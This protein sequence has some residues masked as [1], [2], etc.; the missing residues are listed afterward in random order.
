MLSSNSSP[1]SFLYRKLPTRLTIY[2][3]LFILSV[4]LSLLG[5]GALVYKLEASNLNLD[6]T[7]GIEIFNVHISYSFVLILFSAF[8][9]LS[10][11]LN[12]FKI[13]LYLA[14]LVTF[15]LYLFPE[16]P[17]HRYLILFT[18]PL[19]ISTLFKNRSINNVKQSYIILSIVYFYAF[20]A[21]LNYSYINSDISCAAIFLKNILSLN[22]FT[23]NNSLINIKWLNYLSIYSSIIL[24]FLFCFFILLKRTRKAVII[25]AM[26]FHFCLAE[27]LIKYFINFSAIMY[28]LLFSSLGKLSLI[29]LTQTF[30]NISKIAKLVILI[31]IICP[32]LSHLS[33]AFADQNNLYN[34]FKFLS[35]SRHLLWVS[36]SF[37]IFSHVIFSKLSSYESDSK[38]STGYILLFVLLIVNG[39]SPYL[40]LKT[41]TSFSMYSN[42]IITDESSN[43][44]FISKSLDI[45]GILKNRAYI[46][47]VTGPCI[48]QFIKG[49]EYPIFELSRIMY[50]C[51][52]ADI[53]FD[54]KGVKYSSDQIEGMTLLSESSNSF[55]RSF[56]IFS[57]TDNNAEQCI[58]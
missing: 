50:K 49:A 3:K 22:L 2:I 31:I 45:L 39:I 30:S 5:G 41:R 35:L 55:L 27:D 32:I 33:L 53:K 13:F 36:F 19:V 10:K 8:L 58:W 46:L 6:R 34:S 54:Y 14:S 7:A 11:R 1:D 18:L 9:L 44:L 23:P 16:I 29:K 37:V 43:H 15:F 20:L 51:P 26:I 21:K 17:N 38:V 48:S 47:D 28:F 57:P 25:A 42:L 24:E 52:D 4:Y 40:G 12:R 56:L